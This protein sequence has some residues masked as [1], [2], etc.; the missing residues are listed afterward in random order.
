MW[1]SEEFGSEHVG[2][3]G[4]LLADR[5]E[6]GPVYFDTG[7]GPSVHRSTDWWVYDGTLGAP[8]ATELRGACSCGW[9][10]TVSYPIDWETVDR[11]RPYLAEVSGPEDDWEA[12]IAQVTSRTAPLP[13]D[14]TALLDQVET[15]LDALVADE[16]LAALRA[17]AALERLSRRMAT[18]A[19]FCIDAD[20]GPGWDGVAQ[21]LGISE[22][23]ARSR[24]TRHVLRR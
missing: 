17:A 10:G 11:R 20:G 9:R 22:R 4:V 19:A 13:V 24:M 16:P 18:D 12:H 21:A 3:P 15:R 7:S 2:R 23:A 14:L 5:S 8:S 6:P 1:E